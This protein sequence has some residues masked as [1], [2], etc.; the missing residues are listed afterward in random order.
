MPT[1]SFAQGV[2]YSGTTDVAIRESNPNSAPAEGLGLFVDSNSGAQAQ[3]LLAFAGL[4]GNG[5]GQIPIGATITSATLTLRVTDATATGVSLSRMLIDWPESSSW[6]SLGSGVQ[7]DGIEATSSAD[8]AIA[9]VPIGFQGFDV[10]ASLQAWLAGAATADEANDANNGWVFTALGIDPLTF[11]SSE[12][13]GVPV[14]SVEYTI[15]GLSFA[16]SVVLDEGTSASDTPFV[17]TVNRTGDTSGSASVDWAVTGTGSEPAN[18]SDFAGNAL[19]SGTI[20]FAP[21][22]LSQTITVNVN[23][24]ST[25]EEDETFNVTLSNA[26]GTQITNGTGTGTITNDDEAGLAFDGPVSQAEG[27]S[28]SNTA[29]VFTVNRSGETSGS[30]SVD[31]AVTGLG[32]APA[33]AADFAGNALPGGTI[34]FAAGQLSQTITVNVAADSTVELDEA[35]NVTLSNATGALISGGTSTGTITNDDASLAFAGPVS[36]AEGTSA[37]NTPFVFT[38]NRGGNTSGSASVNWTVTGTGGAPANAGDFAGNTLPGGTIN[39]APGQLSQTITVNV[40]ADSTVEVDETFN[41]SLSNATGAQITGGTGTG[42]IT[43]DDASGGGGGGTATFQQ[44]VNY[45]GTIDVTIRQATPNSAP[46]GALTLFT[47]G[48]SGA[49]VQA[50]LAFTDL[51]GTGFGQIPIGATVTSA[52]LT[53]SVTDASTSSVS[54]SR[55]LIDWSELSSWNSLGSGVQLGVEATGTVAISS[56]ATGLHTYNVT[57]S[58]QA[59]LTGATTAAQANAA[60]D[61]WVFTMSGTDQW[62]VRSSESGVV[63]VLT[64]EYTTAGGGAPQLGFAGP[65]SK[66][67]GTGGPATPFV[68]TVNRSGDTSGSASVNWAV[69]GTG[70]TPATAADFAG[71]AFPSGTINFAAGQQSRTI[72]VNVVADSTNESNET[73]N[74]TLSNP[75]GAQI[76]GGTALG[77]IVNDDVSGGVLGV[78]VHD[79]TTFGPG[80]GSTDPTDVA[81]DPST[82][83]LFVCDSEVDESPFNSQNNL[84]KLQADGDPQQAYSMRNYTSEPTGVVIWQDRLYVC[85][86]NRKMIFVVDK[87][88]PTVLLPGQSFSTTSLGI[89]DPEDLSVNPNNGNLFVLNELNKTIYEIDITPSGPVVVDTILLPSPFPISSTGAEGLVY[90][91]Q[92]DQFYVCAGFSAN[93]YVVNRA[94]VITSTITILTQFPNDG[95]Y[96]VYPKGL[97]LAPASDGSGNLSLWVTDYGRDQVADGRIL[98]IVLDRPALTSAAT[99]TSTLS[100]DSFEAELKVNS[101]F[102]PTLVFDEQS[103]PQLDSGPA[104]HLLMW[105]NAD[106]GGDIWLA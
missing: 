94:G 72:T 44:G 78:I 49:Q 6:N 25:D 97:E 90:D 13:V 54:M 99:T 70:G 84:F 51:F 16:G 46:G 96:R 34:N 86:D 102:H 43:N 31:W 24:D 77:T 80:V 60:N 65:V 64:V 4:F 27:T 57:D 5:P 18:V 63:P 79:G 39:F 9:D 100:L 14:L 12:S 103:L 41:V 85:D 74:V 38:V 50:L 95:G 37:S 75:T 81:Y 71:N 101:A 1:L 33:T 17:F 83:F 93:I 61:G 42:T 11:R 47:D 73:F 7:L 59:W 26:S 10:T 104:D 2:G 32:A 52:T 87:N 67:E 28:P 92:N 20:N 88:N 35:F 55:M 76:S 3:A 105:Q 23:A 15:D 36:Q 19:P 62:A 98:E 89:G 58:L 40:A 21:G 106:L 30:A 8:L 68:F 69:T 22:Q 56:S 29:F 48:D 53:L 66:A 45:F 91:A 82:G